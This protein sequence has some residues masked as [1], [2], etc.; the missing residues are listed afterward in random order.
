[1]LRVARNAA[2]LAVADGMRVVRIL[3]NILLARFLGP[4]GYGTM[5]LARESVRYATLP[6]DMG[7]G[8]YGQAEA[9]RCSAENLPSLAEEVLPARV[10]IGTVLFLLFSGVCTLTIFDSTT[11]LVFLITGVVV[12]AEALRT[13]WLLRG[14]ERFDLLIGARAFESIGFLAVTLIVGSRPYALVFD[15]AG[16]SAAEIV[17]AAVWLIMLRHLFGRALG[18]RVNFRAWLR[19]AR[20]AVCVPIALALVWA[21]WLLLLW[22]VTWLGS[23]SDAGTLAAPYNLTQSLVNLGAV[24]VMAYFPAVA[25]LDRESE[26]FLQ[27]RR[28]FTALMLILS[29]PVASAGG[30]VSAPVIGLTLGAGFHQSAGLF[31]VLI[32]VVPLRLLRMTYSFTLISSGYLKPFLIGPVASFLGTAL[33]GLP[34]YLYYRLPG[35]ALAALGGELFATAATILTSYSCHR[36]AALPRA[37]MLIKIALLN[38]SL[39]LLGPVVIGRFGT[40]AY[41]IS[42]AVFYGAAVAVLGLVDIARIAALFVRSRAS[43]VAGAPS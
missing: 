27:S 39:V 23:R 9:A 32:W 36:D 40:L 35:A 37:A 12:I 15:T 29:L 7:I 25:T 8:T 43:A 31:K 14:R 41:V 1:M 6:A 42:A 24:L 30:V 4:T 17:M 34:L 5:T 13:D 19:H 2:W 33:L 16:W 38:L 10:V 3:T 28:A 21:G 11:R 26:A 22:T 20:E 18:L